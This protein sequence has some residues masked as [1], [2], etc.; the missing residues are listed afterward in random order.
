MLVGSA[1]PG[2]RY[3]AKIWR[4]G[5][6]IERSVVLAKQ[7]ATKMASA[8]TPEAKTHSQIAGMGMTVAALTTDT[9]AAYG[10]SASVKGVIVI[11]VSP[12]GAALE[13]GIRPGDVIVSIGENKVATPADVRRELT[14][15]AA[16][17][18]HAALFLINRKGAELY[19]GLPIPTA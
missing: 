9:R 3:E 5:R 18:N 12:Q 6:T 8:T 7:S 14:N 17:K 16:N 19:V 15:E 4:K 1:K 10:I 11:D 2:Q 13:G